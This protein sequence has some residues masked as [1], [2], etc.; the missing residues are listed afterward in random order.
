M[1]VRALLSAA[2]SVTLGSTVPG[3]AQ[4]MVDVPVLSSDV[5][6]VCGQSK[7]AMRMVC[8]AYL[9]GAFEGLMFGQASA[10]GGRVSFCPPPQGITLED[11]RSSFLEF[12]AH[13]P[14]EQE[15]S[16]SLALLMALEDQ[17]PCEGDDMDTPP[18]ATLP[19]DPPAAG[20]SPSMDDSPILNTNADRRPAEHA[21]IASRAEVAPVR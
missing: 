16:A 18:D 6:D 7:A 15:A 21:L 2:I 20:Q 13:R 1:K 9:H 4:N 12:L 8:A 19:D 10:T 17:Y 14:E 5:L 3:H 11:M